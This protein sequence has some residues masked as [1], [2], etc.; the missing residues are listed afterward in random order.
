MYG[1]CMVSLGLEPNLI[2]RKLDGLGSD[3]STTSILTTL[4]KRRVAGAA[5]NAK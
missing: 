4:T 3:T 2:D 1:Q 5:D